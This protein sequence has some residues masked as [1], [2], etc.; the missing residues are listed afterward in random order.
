MK[1]RN[2]NCGERP[3]FSIIIPTFNRKEIITRAI[4]SLIS[5]TEKSWEAIIIDDGSEDNTYS[6]IFP[7]LEK[8][9]RIQYIRQDN[10]GA[11]LAKNRGI[12]SASGL[13]L[14]FL[15]SDDEY[16]NTHLETRKR[17]LMKNPEVKFLYG[18]IKIVGNPFVPDRFDHQKKIHLDECVIGGTFF[19]ERDLLISLNGFKNIVIGE[20]AELFDRLLMTNTITME[21]QSATYVYRHDRDDSVTNSRM[22]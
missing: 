20:D 4:N 18:G 14:T 7:Y 21:T 9:P 13:F 11:A 8:D 1:N 5:Q 10:T 3:Y 22:K 17:I 6:C 16:H 2:L 19:I 15:D 12:R